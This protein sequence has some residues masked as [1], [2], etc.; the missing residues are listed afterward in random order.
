MSSFTWVWGCSKTGRRRLGEM[1]LGT[2][3][4]GLLSSARGQCAS[5]SVEFVEVVGAAIRTPAS[6]MHLPPKRDR[7]DY[8]FEQ[9]HVGA[10][11]GLNSSRRRRRMRLSSDIPR[12]ARRCAATPS[13]P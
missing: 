5:G 7:S 3:V 2:A 4:G 8:C 13:S 11:Q 1:W 10:H 12:R 6:S 9:Y